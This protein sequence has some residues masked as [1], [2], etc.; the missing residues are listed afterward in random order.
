M[1][2]VRII[3]GGN[4]GA[5]LKLKQDKTTIGRSPENDIV[6]S[7]PSVSRMHAQ[8]IFR[9]NNYYI[10]DLNSTQGTYVNDVRNNYEMLLS[11]DDA[12]RLGATTLLFNHEPPSIVAPSKEDDSLRTPLGA[13]MHGAGKTIT[14]SMSSK[15]IAAPG[16]AE[17]HWAM[18]S[19]VAD[20][21]MSVFDLEELLSRLMDTL[22]EIFKPDRGIIFLYDESHGT[23]NA[24]VA[25]P[26]ESDMKVSQTIISQ[27]V[28]KRLALLIA[29]T[30]VDQRFK[31]TESIVA[32]SIL[33]AI[34]SPLVRKGKVFG[35]IYLDTLSHVLS[36][37]KEDLALLN[38]IAANAAISIENA[39]LIQDKLKAERLAAIGVA[40]AGIS[41][42]VKNIIAGIVG[43]EQL[44]DMGL[45]SDNMSM[46]K[47][48]WPIQKRSTKKIST[49]VQDMLTYSKEREPD[50][51]K[52]NVNTLLRE[53][54]ED[55]LPRAD[56][57]Q[58]ELSLELADDLPDSEF[59]HRAIH[60][61]TLNIVGNAIE[62]CSGLVEP[63]VILRS[64]QPDPQHIA[65]WIID[66][67][68]GIPENI[69]EKIFEPF[70][71]TKGSKGTGLG[72]AVARKSV[73]EHGGSLLLESAP[74]K[75]TTFKIA[76]PLRSASQEDTS[77]AV[78]KS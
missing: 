49:L 63:H 27:A 47:E 46:V 48:V 55:Q 11:E 25:R 43:S 42:Y 7:D 8:I 2:H 20:A 33:S 36:Y 76:L 4:K 65:I 56:N 9:N 66:N 1:A 62:A 54:Y 3:S 18:L 40:I 59:D 72:L 12:I 32:L 34:C 6:L 68:V 31:N 22:F 77:P 50:W 53:I 71:S 23:L 78:R 57:A 30:S 28:D 58:V 64:F 24:K 5:V 41:H 37:Q 75:G 19:K 17:K 45:Q 69:Q 61:A 35:V 67:G 73:E 52:G 16:L 14:F 60:D 70:F 13:P 15:E 38:I 44:I 26:K 39:I 10:Q 29:D 21:T 51:E 74:G